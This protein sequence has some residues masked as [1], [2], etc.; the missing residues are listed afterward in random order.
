[1][2]LSYVA[3][4]HRHLPPPT[5]AV[6]DFD[7]PVLNG[8]AT[9]QRLQADPDLVGIRLIAIAALLDERSSAR[10]WDSYAT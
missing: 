8:C 5:L 9:A 2:R 6:L 3:E 1:M 7:M 10:A 4:L